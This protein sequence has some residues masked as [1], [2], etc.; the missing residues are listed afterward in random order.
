M[1]SIRFPSLIAAQISHSLQGSIAFASKLG[2]LIALATNLAVEVLPV[3]LG[4]Q[5]R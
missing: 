5:N 3:P 4:P 2:Q 1:I